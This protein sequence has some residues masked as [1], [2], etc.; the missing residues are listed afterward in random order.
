M[1][2][3]KEDLK[4]KLVVI[5]GGGGGLAAAV[6]AAERGVRNI[7][8]LEV[9]NAPG[10][11]SLFP[12]GFFAVN[13]Q[14]QKRTGIEASA[15]DSFRTM[16]DHA[17]WRLNSRLVRTL[18]DESGKTVDLL[19]S[20]GVKFELREEFG[21]NQPRVTAPFRIAFPFR[22]GEGKTGLGI[23]KVLIKCC[24]ERGIKIL[25]NTRAKKLVM[26]K[27]G[28]VTGVL[29][30]SEGK[31]F[32][33]STNSA[34]IA[35]G[36]FVGNKEMMKKYLPPFEDEDDIYIYAL[37]HQGDGV[38]MAEEVGAAMESAGA[39][40]ITVNRFPWS[41]FLFIL[42][43]MPSMVWVNKRGVRY[44]DEAGFG[45]LNNLWKQ[46]GKISYTIFDESI[47]K[48]AYQQEV[49]EMDKNYTG[50]FATLD[51]EIQRN[52]WLAVEK[53]LRTKTDTGRIKI[54]DSWAEIARWMGVEPE[55]LQTTIDEYNDGCDKKS[56]YFAKDPQF[57]I[58]LRQPP[59][60][61]IKTVLSLLVTHGV[62]RTSE[63]MEILDKEDNP[64]PGLY[65]A[66]DDVGGTDENVYGALG[67]HSFGFTLV[68]GRLAGE[69][70][71]SYILG[72]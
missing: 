16:M 60:Y 17:H 4:A 72:K 71:A 7:T 44:A 30:E 67:G 28:M 61:A 6:A 55:V 64:L 24:E 49:S 21:R 48:M 37:P 63:R 11:N 14:L 3:K 32:S 40:E 34:V 15:D 19:E 58:P 39:I 47:K 46:P 42:I 9:L 2:V 50:K 20:L 41:S 57:L 69:N 5:G 25:C 18:I 1:A 53:D 35:T 45:G 22:V 62:I 8:V 70:A 68:S 52:P 29:A 54:A 59:Y 66:G 10:G 65:V 38:R 13:S 31:E 12:E 36:G 43:K 33:I 23:M 26:A 27:G 51:E 56:D